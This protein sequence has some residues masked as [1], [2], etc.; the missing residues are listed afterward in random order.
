MHDAPSKK[1]FRLV[2]ALPM[3]MCA[4]LLWPSLSLA[5]AD[6]C[7]QPNNYSH[8]SLAYYSYDESAFAGNIGHVNQENHHFDLLYKLNESWAF[9]V[10]HRYVILGVDPV[11]LQTNGHLHTLFFPL[12]KRTESGNSSF[13]FSIAPALSASSNVMKD[14]GEYSS[15][16]FQLLAALIWSRKLS[17][18]ATLRFGACGDSRFGDYQLYPSIGIDWRPR[19][20]VTIELGF[21]TTRLT[22]QAQ[23]KID[24]SLR[25]AP[26]GNEWHVK[27]K[28]LQ[29]ESQLVA[30]AFLLEGTVN[31]RA[32]KQL[33]VT[34]SIGRQFHSRYDARLSDESSV[35]LYGESV[36]RIGAA[37]DWRF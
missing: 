9:G 6:V 33:T 15:D 7:Q 29:K 1:I 30:E 12:H 25:L 2:N 26:D 13:R 10:G 23:P 16:S 8:L 3:G 31:W 11:E 19:T 36:I 4:C 32:R 35:R 37:V 27:S 5:S 24:F 21:P 14:A 17:E 18:R 34:A 22:Y 28:D 20:D